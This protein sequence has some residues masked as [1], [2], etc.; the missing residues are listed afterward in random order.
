MKHDMRRVCRR[1]GAWTALTLLVVTAGCLSTPERRISKH[2]GLFAGLPPEAQARIRQGEVDLGFTAD[3]VQLAL[4][5]PARVLTRRTVAGALEI[6][7][8]TALRHGTLLRPVRSSYA[9]RGRDGRIHHGLDTGFMEVDRLEEF[10]VLSIE[11]ENGKV[12]AIERLK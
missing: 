9:Y 12:R 8:Y 6:W 11:F 3:M 10:T 4:G 2:P 7:Q 5:N 1:V